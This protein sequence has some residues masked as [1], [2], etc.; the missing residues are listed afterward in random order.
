MLTPTAYLCRHRKIV[1]RV[2]YLLFIC[3][4]LLALA[5]G[6]LTLSLEPVNR[7]NVNVSFLR[8]L[9]TITEKPSDTELHEMAEA[10]PTK[11]GFTLYADLKQIG[12]N[13]Y[14]NLFLYTLY[15]H[16]GAQ[17]FD[18]GWF[19]FDVKA[20]PGN[21]VDSREAAHFSLE[22]GTASDDGE[23]LLPLHSFGDQALIALTLGESP[24]HVHLSSGDDI[25]LNVKNQSPTLGLTVSEQAQVILDNPRLWKTA[26]GM[27][28]ISGGRSIAQSGESTVAIHLVPNN[29]AALLSTLSPFKADKS[30][31]TIKIVINCVTDEGGVVKT[32]HAFPVPVR[33]D[34]SFLSLFLAVTVGSLV[35]TI[36]S[37]L[38]PGAWKNLRSM[39]RQLAVAWGVAVVVEIFAIF[40]VQLGSRFVLFTFELDPWQVL[41]ALFIGFFASGGKNVLDYA[42]ATKAASSTSGQV[43]SEASAGGHHD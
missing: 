8:A 21:F 3:M 28:N 17:A 11:H 15:A 2:G 23:I 43:A 25:Q 6:D 39:L 10:P 27:V 40:L 4:P 31:D 33:F 20:Q 42:G 24:A 38:L 13:K 32:I 1:F 14:A 29:L 30:H 18:R 34:P 9:G 7:Q 26:A 16:D 12:P 22:R 35:A 41:P 36:L 5:Q 37:Q 19:R